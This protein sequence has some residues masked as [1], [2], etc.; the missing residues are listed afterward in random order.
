[1]Y[2]GLFSSFRI[3]RMVQGLEREMNQ[4]ASTVFVELFG[5]VEAAAAASTIALS[6]QSTSCLLLAALVRKLQVCID[7]LA[8]CERCLSSGSSTAVVTSNA[9]RMFDRPVRGRDRRR[10]FWFDGVKFEQR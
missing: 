10:P 4:C 5:S 2:L 7:I 3:I 9:G 8:E 6:G 1:L